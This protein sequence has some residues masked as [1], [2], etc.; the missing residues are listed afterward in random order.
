MKKKVILLP[1]IMM[2][3]ASCGG[4]SSKNSTEPAPSNSTSTST[5]TKPS[6]S[7]S[8]K[9]STSTSTGGSTVTPTKEYGIVD[10]PVAGTA[11]KFGFKQTAKGAMYYMKGEMS[12]FYIASTTNV[13]EATDMFVEEAEGGFHLYFM[14]GTAKK[15]I[16]AETS[17]THLNA[18]I[19][20]SATGVWKYKAE[21]KTLIWSL[22]DKDVF[23]GTFGDYVTFGAS[24][25]DK[26]PTSYVSH[27]YAEGAKGTEPVIEGKKVAVKGVT[28]DESIEV[29]QG[30]TK[31][32]VASV[33]PADATEKGLT[34][35]SNDETKATVDANGVVTG[36][37][38]GETTVT[39]ASKENP[40][41]TAT[42]K[43]TVKE[44]TS[45]GE[46]D[47]ITLTIDSLGLQSQ[48]YADGTVEIS[49]NSF[50]FVELGNYGNGIQMRNRTKASSLWNTAAFAKGIESIEF[51]YNSEKNIS[52]DSAN[53]LKVEFGS[54]NTFAV[55]SKLVSRAAN[56]TTASVKPT[57]N[58]N[59][60]VRFTINATYSL[61]IDSI[62]INFA[63]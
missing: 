52:K 20:D 21:W 29:E 46:V 49:G 32:I 57:A 37:A 60:F 63:K 33:L 1:L 30:K 45:V 47:S 61:Y 25:V 39:V 11:Y 51:T 10:T 59:T 48:K 34:F 54:D 31:K 2:A 6:T 44:A 5:S 23:L 22:T 14:S 43:V 26:A 4:N 15:F 12:G 18:V 24:A 17:G 56:E 38:L 16:Q 19:K 62:V 58:T 8:T 41:F 7:T 50:Q 36:V 13:A 42:V 28:A 9:P 35:K 40:S 3:L 27:F 53:H 55:E